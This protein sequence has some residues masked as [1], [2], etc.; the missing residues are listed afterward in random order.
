[1]AARHLLDGISDRLGAGRLEHE[2]CDL[3]V[4]Q[5][6]GLE[7]WSRPADAAKTS[8]SVASKRDDPRPGSVRSMSQIEYCSSSQETSV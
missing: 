7:T 2:R 5:A 6:R 4:G 8:A 1:M 3:G